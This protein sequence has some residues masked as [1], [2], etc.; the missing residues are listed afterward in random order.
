MVLCWW[1]IR[2][3]KLSGAQFRI[4]A[5]RYL[6]L[7]RK[8]RFATLYEVWILKD[9]LSCDRLA[10]HSLHESRAWRRNLQVVYCCQVREPFQVERCL[11]VLCSIHLHPACQ[12]SK[13]STLDRPPTRLISSQRLNRDQLHNLKTVTQQTSLSSSPLFAEYAFTTW[14]YNSRS[15]IAATRKLVPA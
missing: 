2:A 1:A 14:V 7:P 12:R 5:K 6:H 9:C 10:Q 11:I 4:E 13:K 3:E 15:Q 8:I